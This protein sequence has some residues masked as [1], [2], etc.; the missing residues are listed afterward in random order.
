[1]DIDKLIFAFLM[2]SLAS[3][4]FALALQHVLSFFGRL[5]RH[6]A[7]HVY[8]TSM[9]KAELLGVPHLLPIETGLLIY[10]ALLILG[11]A[12]D[13]GSQRAILHAVLGIFA[14]I[15]YA[16]SALAFANVRGRP[17]DILRISTYALCFAPAALSLSMDY[18]DMVSI[19]PVGMLTALGVNA[20][21]QQM[22]KGVTELPAVLQ[23]LNAID[24]FC[25]TKE[26]WVWVKGADAP[27]GFQDPV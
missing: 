21:T 4:F 6:G 19:I 18:W 22:K 8:E 17:D 27:E 3:V 2:M 25:E 5:G 1:M 24:N 26:D 23:R 15:V 12:M 7:R 20:V 9:A 13:P 16:F 11:S 10:S 14:C